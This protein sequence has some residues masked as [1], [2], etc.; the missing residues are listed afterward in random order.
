MPVLAPAPVVSFFEFWPGWLF[1]L[2]VWLWVAWLSLR[3]RGIRLPLVANPLF[4]AGGLFGEVKSDIL[5]QLGGDAPPR[6]RGPSCP[7]STARA[8][9]RRACATCST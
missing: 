8:L 6:G 5:D 3:H 4:P 2:P 9:R 7:N 1:Y